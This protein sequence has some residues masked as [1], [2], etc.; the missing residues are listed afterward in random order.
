[1]NFPRRAKLAFIMVLFGA[2]FS[3]E[4]LSEAL[5][6]VVCEVEQKVSMRPRPSRVRV[7]VPI[8]QFVVDYRGGV[9]V[10][11]VFFDALRGKSTELQV[12]KYGNGPGNF[13]VAVLDALP[14]GGIK[15][16]FGD[17]QLL[18]NGPS[19]KATFIFSDL[20]SASAVDLRVE[21]RCQMTT[22]V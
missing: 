13:T 3:L 17:I 2:V 11:A 20:E 18:E 8:Y 7:E 9:P 21:A 4:A 10:R 12:G 22:A 14:P 6:T 15:G 19:Q 16:V 5:S 1:M